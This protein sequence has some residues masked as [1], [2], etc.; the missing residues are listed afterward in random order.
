MPTTLPG[1]LLFVAL[2]LP[3]FTFV[4]TM[5]RNRPDRRSSVFEE[6]ASVGLVSV[7][8]LIV[9]L[10]IFGLIRVAAPSL[11]PDVGRL[12][13]D[14]GE[15][16]ETHYASVS[17]WVIGLLLVASALAWIA[18]I[19]LGERPAHPSGASAW[20]RMFEEWRLNRHVRVRCRLDDGSWV[21]GT[22]ASFSNAAD[23]SADRDLILIEPISY[24]LPNETRAVPH[25]AHAVCLSA[26]RIVAVF[27]TYR[28]D[29]V[30]SAATSSESAS[31]P[32][33]TSHP[34]STPRSPSPAADHPGPQQSVSRPRE[35]P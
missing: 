12:V 18:A 16:V 30:A 17:L 31:Q 35:H 3:G 9:A 34:A 7:L 26:R 33:S 23:D 11:T 5:R 8:A 28:G 29:E 4:L 25:E 21:E 19:L 24:T 6:T 15:Y 2:L 22:I 1:L 20:W 14:P 32:A 10:G 13:S 27:V